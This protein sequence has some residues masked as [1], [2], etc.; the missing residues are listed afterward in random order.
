[1]LKGKLE[2]V[3]DEFFDRIEEPGSLIWKKEWGNAI[4]NEIFT[5]Y[6]KILSKPDKT[7]KFTKGLE[8]EEGF[9]GFVNLN[10]FKISFEKRNLANMNLVISKMDGKFVYLRDGFFRYLQTEEKK[11]DNSSK[12][13]LFMKGKSYTQ[14][15]Y[16]KLKGDDSELFYFANYNHFCEEG[17]HIWDLASFDKKNLDK[18]LEFAEQ[19]LGA[20][21]MSFKEEKIP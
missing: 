9:S 20:K 12:T 16:S 1:M 3:S 14:R 2:E 5:D 19:Y 13:L 21:I 4:S 18:I 17:Y 10:S 15:I 6:A 8:F 11:K 7:L